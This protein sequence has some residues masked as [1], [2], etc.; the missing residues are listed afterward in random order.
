MRAS[1]P[2]AAFLNA[3]ASHVLDLDDVY[4]PPRTTVHG[5]CSVWPTVFAMSEIATVSGARALTAFVLG[6][7]AETRVAQASGPAHYEA[8]WHVTGTSGHV[9]A[10]A[11]AAHA[12]GL[13][14][15]ATLH[16]IGAGATQAAGLRVMAGSDLKSLHPA[17]AAQ[18]GVVSALLARAGLT[19]STQPLEGSY[20]YLEVMSSAAEPERLTADL[21][22]T[23]ALSA[24]GHKL[25]PSGSLTHPMIDGVVA[26][27][28]HAGTTGADVARIVVSVSPPAARFTDIRDPTT[29]MQAKFS[30]THCAAAA[31]AFG[32]VGPDE[33][34]TEVVIRHDLAQLR[35]RVTV[36]ADQEMGKQD[37]VVEIELVDGRTL[38]HEVRGNRGTPA[39]PLTDAE[40][41]G[42]FRDLVE[43]RF[44]DT[45]VRRLLDACWHVDELADVAEI[46]ALTS[47]VVHA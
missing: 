35:D 33:L 3:F 46:S 29:G 5:S 24:N 39:S 10:A 36:M 47:E 22:Q 11:A 30:L 2:Y 26:L 37:A 4:N 23:W 21:G 15:T 43:S 27:V 45:R 18:D 34:S 7:E 32:R 28:T 31:A 38:R 40:L 25:Y 20:G 6:F 17:K 16:A 42:K 44:G 19:A 8:G 9:G 13:D 12:A 14:P 1:A 41:E